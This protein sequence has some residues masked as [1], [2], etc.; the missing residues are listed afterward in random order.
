MTQTDE[1]TARLERIRFRQ[2]AGYVDT[3]WM[4]NEIERYEKRWA[5]LRHFLQGYREDSALDEWVYAGQTLDEMDRL[6]R[7]VEG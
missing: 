7:K 2:K 1:R 4:L 6:D 3:A 5:A